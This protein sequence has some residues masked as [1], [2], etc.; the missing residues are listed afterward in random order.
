MD[1]E[2]SPVATDPLVDTVDEAAEPVPDVAE[3]VPDPMAEALADDLGP[4]EAETEELAGPETGLEVG[5]RG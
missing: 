5:E 4:P 3:P 2:R 1:P